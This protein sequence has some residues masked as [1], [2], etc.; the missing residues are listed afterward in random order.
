MKKFFY[1]A[2][3]LILCSGKDAKLDPGKGRNLHVPEPSDICTASDGG[4]YVVSDNGILF[5]LNSEYKIEKESSFKGFD[6]EGVYADDSL[7][8]VSDESLRQVVIFY[9]QTLLVKEIKSFTYSGGR[10]LGMESLVYD[11]MNGKYIG[12]TEKE[13]CLLLQFDKNFSLIS[14][15][16]LDGI[17][18]VSSITFYNNALWVLSDEGMSITKLDPITFQTISKWEVPILNPEGICFS[19]TGKLLIV[20]DDQE[21]LFELT[22][23]N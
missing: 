11:V 18:E 5:K 13:P 20:S 22:I 3:A 23:P 14:Q 1:C 16:P 10:N 8:Y 9:A 17:Q 7:V 6:F 21:E 15:R 12:F 4:Y 2:I 19:K